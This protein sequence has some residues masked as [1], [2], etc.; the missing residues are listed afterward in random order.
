LLF[1][2]GTADYFI[3]NLSPEKIA[4]ID[5]ERYYI[6]NIPGSME[7][8]AL[9]RPHVN[10]ENGI[11]KEYEGVSNTFYCCEEEQLL[12]FKGKEPNLYWKEYSDLLF[13]FAESCGIRNLYFVGSFA[14]VVPHTREPKFHC[15]VSDRRL[16]AGLEEKG[17][18]PSNY[19]GPGSIVTYLTSQAQQ[20]DMRMISLV[21]EIP[22]YIQ[23]R[24]VKCI[25]A[26]CTQLAEMLKLDVNRSEWDILT[27]AFD[28]AISKI[29][30]DRPEL[31]EHIRKMENDYDRAELNKEMDDLK[32]WFEKQGVRLD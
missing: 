9:F 14:G 8:S 10:I 7:I 5:S 22:A 26:A 19:E 1:S 16:L 4:E 28:M 3:E 17:I 11:V 13:S 29:I 27:E 24:N 18:N 12:I 30:E 20:W 6:Y 32:E 2:T 23:G 25:G 15:S 21:S 31:L